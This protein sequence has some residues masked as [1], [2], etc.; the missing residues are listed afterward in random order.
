[1]GEHRQKEAYEAAVIESQQHSKRDSAISGVMS[2]VGHFIQRWSNAVL[3]FWGGW[4]LLEYPEMFEFQDF[5]ISQFA[6][7]FCLLGL[8]A[9]LQ[10]MDDRSEVEA[11]AKWIFSILDRQSA[12]DPL[13]EEG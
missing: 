2:G 5:L 1:M 3:Y 13:S 10:D 9:A 8:A 7:I 11:S 6:F 12:I 4:L